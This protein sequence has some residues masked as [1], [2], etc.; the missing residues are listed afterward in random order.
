MVYCSRP[1]NEIPNGKW[2]LSLVKAE[3]FDPSDDQCRH[4]AAKPLLE[5]ETERK[6]N[7]GQLGLGANGEE[8]FCVDCIEQIMVSGK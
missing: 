6:V 4:V 1:Y 3:D 5:L 8:W 2:Y 7:H